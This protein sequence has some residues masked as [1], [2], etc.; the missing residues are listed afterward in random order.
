[1]ATTTTTGKSMI[2]AFLETTVSLTWIF[3]SAI[4]FS[5]SKRSVIYGDN[6]ASGVAPSLKE[7]GAPVCLARRKASRASRAERMQLMV[8]HRMYF[9]PNT[10]LEKSPFAADGSFIRGVATQHLRRHVWC[11]G[12]VHSNLSP[13]ARCCVDSARRA[14]SR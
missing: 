10:H 3:A 11:R 6:V 7:K 5:I 4:P 1:M 12:H 13:A 14:V 8:I 9:S 2:H